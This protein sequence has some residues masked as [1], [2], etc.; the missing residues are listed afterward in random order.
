MKL[1]FK[2]NGFTL[3]EILI[4]VTMIT[5]IFGMVYGT[6]SAISKSIRSYD[7]RRELILPAKTVM[8]QISR[9]L[10]CV[11][12]PLQ[13]NETENP[14]NF[15]SGSETLDN[16]LNFVTAGDNG[17]YQTSYKFDHADGT[18]FYKQK[19][20][21]ALAVNNE[22]NNNWRPIASNIEKMSFNFYD[23]INWQQ[24]W[25]WKE[26]QRLPRAVSIELSIKDKRGVEYKYET[27]AFVC[28]AQN[29][30]NQIE[31][32]QLASARN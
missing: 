2:K 32:K 17:L 5:L 22:I 28:F 12:A 6:S 1:N 14:V 27:T 18:L 26:K 31:S 13:N 10:R 23:G 7:S 16:V 24:N 20:F 9:Q 25:N 19:P 4:A 30:Q 3:I 8:T 11:Y 21:T 15:F 29:Q